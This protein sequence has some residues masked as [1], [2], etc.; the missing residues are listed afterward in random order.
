MRLVLGWN[1]YAETHYAAAKVGRNRDPFFFDGDG[2]G[3]GDR[4][5][6]GH[7][8]GGGDHYDGGDESTKKVSKMGMVMVT[9]E[10]KV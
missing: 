4:D 5:D 1:A 7:G 8:C 6:H 9:V 2:D 10:A 3:D